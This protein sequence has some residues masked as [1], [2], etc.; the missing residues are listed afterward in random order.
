MG[1]ERKAGYWGCMG[2]GA[3]KQQ[4]SIS[5]V[6]VSALKCPCLEVNKQGGSKRGR[7]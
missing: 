6:T 7:V 3:R 2:T 4:L 1:W 5:Y